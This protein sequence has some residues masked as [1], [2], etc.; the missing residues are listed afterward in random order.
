M[1]SF[2]LFLWLAWAALARKRVELLFHYVHDFESDAW[3][4]GKVVWVTPTHLEYQIQWDADTKTRMVLPI[5]QIIAAKL[6]TKPREDLA[7]E[8]EA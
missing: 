7:D 2:T 4:P 6:Y 8:E 5:D 3:L 1:E